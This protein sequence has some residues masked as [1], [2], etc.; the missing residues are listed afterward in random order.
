MISRLHDGE[1]LQERVIDP[2]PSLRKRA[3]ASTAFISE[4]RTNVEVIYAV[5]DID[6]SNAAELD[7]A[8]TMAGV[9]GKPLTVDLHECTYLDMAGLSVLVRWKKRL[10]ERF[11]VCVLPD[12]FIRR[13][14]DLA[15][16]SWLLNA[17]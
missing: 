6:I 3:I 17:T 8:I 2:T 12:S 14:F 5:G 4:S 10:H 11:G 9:H 1:P 13:V 16:A 15:G 7:A